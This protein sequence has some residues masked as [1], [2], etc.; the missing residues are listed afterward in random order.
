MLFYKFFYIAYDHK[1]VFINTRYY[2]I[3]RQLTCPVP[4]PDPPVWKIYDAVSKADG[5][6]WLILIIIHGILYLTHV[7]YWY[8]RLI[9]L[10]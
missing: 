4:E 9:L 5:K 1:Q 6:V 7:S 10:R 8:I 2:S 3:G